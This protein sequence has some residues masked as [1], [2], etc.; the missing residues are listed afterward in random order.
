MTQFCRYAQCRA[1]HLLVCSYNTLPVQGT[2]P[3]SQILATI[4]MSIYHA[5]LTPRSIRHRSYVYGNARQFCHQL[6]CIFCTPLCKIQYLADYSCFPGLVILFTAGLLAEKLC[7][8]PGSISSVDATQGHL[9]IIP[10][11][12]D[13]AFFDNTGESR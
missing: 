6:A 3:S 5:N 2:K 1:P 4:N 7:R 8:I 12:R 9:R 11:E 10:P 13:H